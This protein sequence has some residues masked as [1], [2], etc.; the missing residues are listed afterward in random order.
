MAAALLI[1]GDYQ[2]TLLTEMFITIF[3]LIPEA[4]SK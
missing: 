3:E 4:F 1:F 2:L